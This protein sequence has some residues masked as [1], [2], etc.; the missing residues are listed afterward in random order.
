MEN[1]RTVLSVITMAILLLGAGLLLLTG[2]NGG[3]PLLV[4][5]EFRDVNPLLEGNHVRVFGGIAG[6]VK[7]IELTERETV[8]VTMALNEGIERPHA[9]ASAAVR[10]EDL[11]GENYLSLSLGHDPRPLSGPIP[12]ERTIVRPR[13][14]DVLNTFKGDVRAGLQALLVELGLT[15]D[16][17]GVDLNAAI[18]DLRPAL[19]QTRQLVQEAS[20]QNAGLR[21]LIP[22]VERATRQLAARDRELDRLLPAFART[23]QATASRPAQLDRGLEALPA[24]L[25]QTRSTARRLTSM[26][27]QAAPL[28]RDLRTVAPRLT[29]TAG[30]LA[31]FVR[32]AD[33]AV[34]S[35]SPTLAGAR[36][37]LVSGSPAL[38][39]LR[40]GLQSLQSA[41]PAVDQL[42]T[43]LTR[44]QD[45][46][47]PISTVNVPQEGVG[48]PPQPGRVLVKDVSAIQRLS[49]SFLDKRLSFFN[50]YTDFGFPGH[51]RERRTVRG[52]GV[53]A[54][55]SFGLTNTP[56]CLQD[57]VIR[58]R[59][60][61]NR[62]RGGL[63]RAYP[64]S[65]VA[66]AGVDLRKIA[67]LARRDR[68]ARPERGRPERAL[69]DVVDEVRKRLPKADQ[70]PQG[71]GK[72]IGDAI[73]KI[74]R[75]KVRPPAQDAAPGRAPDVRPLLDFLMGP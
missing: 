11:L 3:G 54:C 38:A 7:K 74:V 4:K 64:S 60:F 9:D 55:S 24:T 40:T 25:R 19:D 58:L 17:R 42:L 34:A 57:T 71:A 22:D 31:P 70:A 26:T 67:P 51:N 46:V 61:Y 28:A 21:R 18:V 10:A 20:S 50:T 53:L 44:P 12:L 65:A 68:R 23:V 27:E 13:L 29:T 36:R 56:G 66:L 49:D 75:P 33:K 8:M 45:P 73:D 32:S 6:T 69:P 16:R 2:T 59:R 15:L 43:G 63:S 41:A 52:L 48:G 47:G 1:G 72:A 37:F 62:V 30:L 35:L 5:A 14:A 39:E